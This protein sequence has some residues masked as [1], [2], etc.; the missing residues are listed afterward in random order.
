M[1]SGLLYIVA[2][3]LGTSMPSKREH[4]IVPQVVQQ[5]WVDIVQDETLPPVLQQIAQCESHGQPWT[6]ERTVH[7]IAMLLEHTQAMV[8]HYDRFL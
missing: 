5:T 8:L 3:V 6:R 4:D 2:A 7:G 1:M